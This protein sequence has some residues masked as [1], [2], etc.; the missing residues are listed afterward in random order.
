M[1]FNKL[2]AVE[3]ATKKTREIPWSFSSFRRERRGSNHPK[4]TNFSREGR[5]A[6]A[7]SG[8]YCDKISHLRPNSTNFYSLFH[9]HYFGHDPPC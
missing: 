6:P 1:K 8:P 9:R 4:P 3:N 7:I 5:V 2:K